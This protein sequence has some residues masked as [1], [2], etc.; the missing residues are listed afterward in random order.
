MQFCEPVRWLKRKPDVNTT[1]KH[2]ANG[3]RGWR[4]LQFRAFTLIEL[5]VVIAIIAILAAMLL[6]ALSRAKSKA[7]R[8]ACLNNLRQIGL[9]L[10]MYTDEND[11]RFPVC[12]KTWS[13]DSYVSNWW[14]WTIVGYGNSNL[15][16]CPALKGQRTDNGVSWKWSFDF[17]GVGYGMNSFFLDATP[18]PVG[19]VFMSGE[20]YYRNFSYKRSAIKSPVDCL[21]VADSMPKPDGKSSGSLWWPNACMNKQYGT[22]F[23]G[24]ETERHYKAG[25]IGFA[26]G[27]SEARRDENINPAKNP[28]NE[29]ALPNTRYWDPEQRGQ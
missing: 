5:L 26:D 15:F 18:N 24:V 3:R 20:K 28:P 12:V 2:G 4:A 16:H 22:S 29:E 14:G 19:G 25:V 17:N 11:D 7:T 13:T 27:H 9:F 21:V 10:Q 6:P 8:T 23:E 1:E